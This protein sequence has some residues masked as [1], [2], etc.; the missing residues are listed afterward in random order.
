MNIQDWFPLGLTGWISLQ[1][2]G[3]PRLF[4]K[5]KA[6]IL[7]RLAFFMVQISHPY[8]TTGRTIALTIQTFVGKVMSL[9]FNMLSRFL[10]ALLPRSS[11]VKATQS[12]PI[13]CDPIAYTVHGILHASILEW[14]AFPFYSRSSQPRD[15]TWASCITKG[16]VTS[17]ATREDLEWVVY[18]NWAIREAQASFNSMAAVTIHSD[19]GVQ[20]SEI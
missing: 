2:K 5:T 1:S 14:G 8:M 6:S 19:F 12:C 13:L 16:F 18:I 10:I 7:Q 3:L 17:W 9:L 15:Q 20:K 4:S 11:E